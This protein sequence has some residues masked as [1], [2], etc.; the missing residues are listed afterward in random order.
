MP[1]K[2]KIDLTKVELELGSPVQQQPI[3]KIVQD[4]Y[5]DFG[6]NAYT[7]CGKPWTTVLCSLV[8][9]WLFVGWQGNR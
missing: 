9:G 8:C 2:K 7:Y 4:A 6:N 5:I 3:G 1:R